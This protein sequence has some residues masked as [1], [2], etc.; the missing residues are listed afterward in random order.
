MTNFTNKSVIF[1]KPGRHHAGVTGLYLFVS[2][3]EQVRR[4]VFRFTSPLTRRVTETGLGL[5]QVLPPAEARAKALDLQRQIAQGIC[6]VQAKRVRFEKIATFAE[7]CD[8]WIEAHRPGW[9]SE[10]QMRNAHVL[11]KLHGS[12]LKNIPVSAITAEQVHHALTDLWARH[13]SQARRA[14][15]MWERV[16]DYAK[17]KQMRLGD[18]PA[19]WRAN[20]EYRF[21]RRQ[22]IANKHHAAMDYVEIPGFIK[23]LRQRQDRSVGARALEFLILT[24]A[25]TG[26]VRGMVWDEIDWDQKI[27][28]LVGMRTKQGRPHRVPLSNQAMELLE[29]LRK[30]GTSPHVFRGYRNQLSGNAMIWVLQDLGLKITVHGFR[31]SFRSWAGDKTGFA[32]EHIEECL[33]HAVGNQTERAYRRSDAL[34]KRRVIL[35]TW[36][37]FCH[38][39]T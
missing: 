11:L 15:A 7:C 22:N 17:A 37:D 29:R 35:Q 31:A 4:W 39:Q 26:E 24:C 6:P 1:A 28:S 23:E 38:D 19:A 3:D 13:P 34:E 27:W 12:R 2:P 20:M 10:S 30:C 25:R 14:L 9:R 16:F 5:V 36:S 33:G 32:R 18:N 8:A 21:P